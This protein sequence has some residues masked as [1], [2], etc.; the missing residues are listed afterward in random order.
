MMFSKH[1]LLIIQTA[2]AALL[3]MQFNGKLV[4]WQRVFLP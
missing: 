4:Y 3:E 2:K 1:C